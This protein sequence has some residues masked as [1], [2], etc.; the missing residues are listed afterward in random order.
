MAKG[1]RVIANSKEIANHIMKV[2]GVPE[3]RIV[4]IYRGVDERTFNP[5]LV[6]M[7]RIRR[8]GCQWRLNDGQLNRGRINEGQSNDGTPPVIMLPGRLTAW[9]GQDIFI[10]SLSRVKALPWMAV[11]VGDLDEHPS[12][13]KRLQN[14]IFRE[15]LENRVRLVG[16]CDDM[17]AAYMISDVVVS[18]SSTE[19]EAFGR[20]SIEAQAMGKPVIATAHGGSLETVL[21]G[22]TGWLVKP[23]DVGDLAKAL[24]EALQDRTSCINLGRKGREWVLENFTVKRMC[25]ETVALYHRLIQEKNVRPKSKIYKE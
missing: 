10:Q 23:C 20:I 4:I 22:K 11:C 5:A 24:C 1:E 2:Y 7:E 17:P 12:Y 8:I 16:H 6:S 19:P 13:T 18:A 9:K 3:D 25:R 21:E 15:Q 14:L